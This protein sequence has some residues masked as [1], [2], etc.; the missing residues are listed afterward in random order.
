MSEGGAVALLRVVHSPGAPMTILVTD[1]AE[2][3]CNDVGHLSPTAALT[4]AIK[5][6][7]APLRRGLFVGHRH[8]MR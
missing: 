2:E 1:M 3:I 8:K 4:V 5:V 7:T 6:H